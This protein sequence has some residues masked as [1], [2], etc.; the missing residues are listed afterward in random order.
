MI[1]PVSDAADVLTALVLPH[2]SEYFVFSHLYC[3]PVSL[4]GIA[5]GYGLD[6]PEIE[7][8][9]G[10]EIFRTCPDRPWGTASLL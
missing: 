10:G 1:L 8:Q 5:T 7:S 9:G 3:G 2:V 6:G 4:V